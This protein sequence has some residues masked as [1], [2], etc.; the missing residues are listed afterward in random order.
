MSQYLKLFKPRNLFDGY[1]IARQVKT[2]QKGTPRRK[3]VIGEGPGYPKTMFPSSQGGSTRYT[4][5]TYQGPKSL[6]FNV[7]PQPVGGYV[8]ST[9]L[10][11]KSLSQ[12]NRS[13]AF[14]VLPNTPQVTG[15]IRR[16]YIN[17]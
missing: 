1:L 9:K 16:S 3:I 13:S 14:D 10:P 2:I 15:V 12:V 17:L 4:K 5:P 11:T 7:R 8:V 6:S